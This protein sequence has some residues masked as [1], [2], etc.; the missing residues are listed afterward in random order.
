MRAP[1]SASH[2]DS[3]THW[4]ACTPLLRSTRIHWLIIRIHAPTTVRQQQDSGCPADHPRRDLIRHNALPL[5]PHPSRR[6]FA[7]PR[8][9]KEPRVTHSP[10]AMSTNRDRASKVAIAIL[11]ILLIALLAFFFMTTAKL[12]AGAAQLSEGATAAHDGSTKL[13]DG[14]TKLSAGSGDL[15]AGAV[16][17]ADGAAALFAGATTA[18]VGADKVAAE[19]AS[20]SEGASKLVEGAS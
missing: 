1:F 14:A 7:A 16:T 12:S 5:C 9:S 3:S 18:S 17:L 4:G 8:N 13:F 10:S 6:Q 20:A 15:K 19:A 11:S 2:T